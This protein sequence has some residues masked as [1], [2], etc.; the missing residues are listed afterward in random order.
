M[1]KMCDPVVIDVYKQIGPFKI[2]RSDVPTKIKNM[3]SSLEYRKSI[4]LINNMEYYCGQ[5][6][7]G[8]EVRNGRGISVGTKSTDSKDS[9]VKELYEGF[10][11]N[12]FSH[13]MGRQIYAN[14]TYYVGEFVMGVKEGKGKLIWQ[15]GS[16]FNGCFKNNVFDG[17]GVYK[18]ANCNYY[19]G[20]F[21][22]GKMN[23]V[24]VFK[25]T[26]GR[27]Y[28]GEFFNGSRHGK[29]NYKS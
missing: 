14:G 28:E 12:N 2:K 18:W 1:I 13:G 7:I 9:G 20:M 25:W 26:D 8:S 4:V 15:D 17:E 24:G 11:F 6:S 22:N 23:G 10:W 29:G 5:W 16:E 21:R 27:V 19:V 3:L